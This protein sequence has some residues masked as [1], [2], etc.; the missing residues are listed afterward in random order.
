MSDRDSVA[1]DSLAARFVVRLHSAVRDAAV[2]GDTLRLTLPY[3][4]APKDAP[5]PFPA[6]A[7]LLPLLAP[8]GLTLQD[9][10]ARAETIEGGW[11]AIAPALEHLARK[12]PVV[13]YSGLAHQPGVGR[14]SVNV[15]LAAVDALARL[16]NRTPVRQGL[17][18][19]I[20][21]QES[22]LV[23]VGLIDMLVQMKAPGVAP[24]MAK[25]ARDKQVDEVVQQRAAWAVEKMGG[26]R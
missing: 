10:R 9:L 12:R 2:I 22:P 20:P 18:N 21:K 8:P 16:S 23:Q 1:F 17:R 11:S 3:W 15:R 14:E 4:D 6:G 13:L 19:A 25:L 5:F 24:S 7:L 26:S